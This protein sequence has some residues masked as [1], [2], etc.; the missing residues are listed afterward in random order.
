[1]ALLAIE[2]S[3]SGCSAAV[4]HDGDV[5]AERRVALARGHA[6]ALLPLVRAAMADAAGV[7]LA[8]DAL[9][10]VAVTVGPGSFTGIRVGLAAA[11]G[12]GL[13][14]AIP[15]LGL[16][17]FE[18]IAAGV[19][20]AA[21]GAGALAVV[22]D[23]GRASRFVQ[24]FDAALAPLGPPAAIELDRLAAAL[25]P[26][27]CL[28]AADGPLPPPAAGDRPVLAVSPDAAVLA[29]LAAARRTAG[30]TF[31]PPSALYL[32]PPDASVP[33]AGGRIRA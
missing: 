21:H 8:W 23:S 27:P 3:G 28:V 31:L 11:R 32:R 1:M 7:G 24:A 13:A 10:A 25:P 4:W 15:V 22:I 19:P 6:A 2:S 17:S 33:R 16:T 20:A 12:V 30:A 14:R 5:V 26:P 29:C 9:T 18:V